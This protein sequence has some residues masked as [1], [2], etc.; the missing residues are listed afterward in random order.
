[1]K[2]TTKLLIKYCAERRGQL[3]RNTHSDDRKWFA[4]L[5]RRVRNDRGTKTIVGWLLTYES[6]GTFRKW[7]H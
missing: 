5:Q 3:G 6:E 2:E 4:E 1:M 7:S